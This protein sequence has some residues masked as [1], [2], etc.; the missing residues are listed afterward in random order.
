MSSCASYKMY[1]T[2]YTSEK[3][4]LSDNDHRLYLIKFRTANSK[5]PVV[6][7]RYSGAPREERICTLCH[8]NEIGDEYHFLL[9][10]DNKRLQGYKE[11]YI[12][13][14]YRKRA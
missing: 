7:E 13:L 9:G 5:L 3:Y 1:K 2:I 4:L 12:P 14:Y 10:C 6:I 8:L 11:L